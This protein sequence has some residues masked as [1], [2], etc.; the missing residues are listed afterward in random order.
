MRLF[1]VQVD[2]LAEASLTVYLSDGSTV[3]VT[4][5]DL[6]WL[7]SQGSCDPEADPE[8]EVNPKKWD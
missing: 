4:L 2:K 1:I 5:D 6:L 3:E 8:A 7:R